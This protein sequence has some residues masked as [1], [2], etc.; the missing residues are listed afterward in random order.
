MRRANQEL[1]LDLSQSLLKEDLGI[2]SEMLLR[3]IIL[4]S[5]EAPSIMSVR[6]EGVPHE[7][8]AIEGIIEDMTHIVLNLKNALAQKTAH[9]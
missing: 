2:P 4:S 7:Y 6:I 9:G 1:L 3:R 8:M 5:L